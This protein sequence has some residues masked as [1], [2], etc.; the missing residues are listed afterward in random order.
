MQRFEAPLLVSTLIWVWGST[1]YAQESLSL[2]DAIARARAG[3][4]DARLAEL[5]E[6]RAST[7]VAEARAGWFPKLDLV[8]S[9]QYGNQPVF[10]FSSLL[11]QRRFSASNFDIAALNRPEP[12]D[13]FRSAVLVEQTIFDANLWPSQRAARLGVEAAG[14][15]RRRVTQQVTTEVVAAFGRVWLFDALAAAAHAAIATADQDVERARR[16]R[17]V[18]LATDADVLSAEVHRAAVRER[19]IETTSEA[20]IARGA[21]NRLMGVPIDTRY[22]LDRI[23]PAEAAPLSA[24]AEGSGLAA[25]ADVQL[26]ALRIEQAAA[27][28]GAARAAFL[29]QLVARGG[30]EW[31]GATFTSRERAWSVGAELRVSLF[32]G[33]DRARVTRA[34]V[35]Q[36]ERQLEAEDAATRA[37]LDIRAAAARVEAAQAR[38]ETAA[39]AVAQARESHRILRDRYDAGLVDIT[40]VLRASQARL[41]A[42]ARAIAAEVD[43]AVQRALLEA[44]LGR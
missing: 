11:S 18:G 10:V 37:R 1:A 20:A 27:A 4:V 33:A 32:R 30:V 5:A 36:D 41:D 25:R 39:A 21:L 38:H 28:I 31:H 24:E 7:S 43:R 14:L 26:A 3:H 19:E 9:W 42:D 34:Q 35:A 23:P 17:D 16:R 44:A 13:D 2:A 15:D 8:E 6:T 40:S 29:P 22:Q 12:T